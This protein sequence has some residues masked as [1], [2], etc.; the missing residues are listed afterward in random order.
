MSV[1]GCVFF[2][3]SHFS[4][5]PSFSFPHHHTFHLTTLSHSHGTFSIPPS[6]LLAL[7]LKPGPYWPYL[8]LLLRRKALEY[9]FLL[10]NE[11]RQ[12]THTQQVCSIHRQFAQVCFG[13]F[14]VSPSIFGLW[15]SN[16][17][18]IDRIY[19]RYWDEKRWSIGSYSVTNVGSA[20]IHNNN[21]FAP[22]I[23][24]LRRCALVVLAYLH[25]YLDSGLQTWPIL[26][27]FTLAIETKSAG[28]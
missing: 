19:T 18:H 27:V 8:H 17:A 28:V 15:P 21:K 11:R 9:R 7:A 3:I 24:N 10:G 4:L 1:F 13:S 26:T 12:C 16:L 2:F 25:Q 20:H 6:I 22:S 14:S 23:G 5:F